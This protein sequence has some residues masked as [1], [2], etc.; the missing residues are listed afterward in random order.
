[1]DDL[2]SSALLLSFGVDLTPY[3]LSKSMDSISA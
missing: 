1:M 2:L 3:L